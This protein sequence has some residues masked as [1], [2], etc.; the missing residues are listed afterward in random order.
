MAFFII[1]LLMIW[2][3]SPT[4]LEMT[5][6]VCSIAGFIWGVVW[7]ATERITSPITREIGQMREE[8]RQMGEGIRED[9]RRMREDFRQMREDFL[10]ELARTREDLLK[11][12]NEIRDL[13]KR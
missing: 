1:G 2:L 13:L 3:G 10:K 7:A 5:G 6:S 4:Q 8:L 12:L 11:P 9:F